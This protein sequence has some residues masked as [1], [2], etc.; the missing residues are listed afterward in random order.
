M[1]PV[2]SYHASNKIPFHEVKIEC[3]CGEITQLL[4]PKKFHE[5]GMEEVDVHQSLIDGYLDYLFTSKLSV[6]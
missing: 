5:Q 3:K 2:S 6:P 1:N 4:A